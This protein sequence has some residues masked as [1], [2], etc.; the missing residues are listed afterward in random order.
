MKEQEEIWIPVIGYEHYLV[1]NHG[2][3]R[4][5]PRI[6]EFKN[7]RHKNAT[8]SK[9]RCR[10][11]MLKA[12]NVNG[13]WLVV[14]RNN[15]NKCATGVHRLVAKHFIPNPENKSEVNHKDGNR[16]NNHVSN[17]EWVTRHENYMHAVKNQLHARGEQAAKSKLN[18]SFV[19]AIRFLAKNGVSNKMLAEAFGVTSPT[20]TNVIK[21]GTWNHVI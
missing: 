2:R 17:L 15:G 16:L 14:L 19:V 5:L 20:I 7:K 13:Y 4:S 6:I 1:S 8:S 11:M 9:Y 18:N 3:V 10:D 12:S 21:R